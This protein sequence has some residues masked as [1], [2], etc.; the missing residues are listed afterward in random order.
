[1]AQKLT[2]EQ[3]IIE[4]RKM[5]NWIADNLGKTKGTVY[6]LKVIYCEENGFKY[7]CAHCFCCQYAHFNCDY[8]PL[9]WGS[10]NDEFNTYC[11]SDIENAVN[12]LNSDSL[13]MKNKFKEAAEIARKIANLPEKVY[14][15]K[16]CGNIHFTYDE[17]IKEA[18][19]L[20]DIEDPTN[21]N[22]WKEYYEVK[23]LL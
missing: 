9:Y 11:E 8:C 23:P 17:M 10:E 5:W 19:E 21:P 20:Y 6:D 7:L 18:M 12:W 22:N 3:A 15:N 13:S 14:Q 1:M 4:H 2:R 16:E